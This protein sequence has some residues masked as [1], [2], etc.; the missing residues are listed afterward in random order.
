[1]QNLFTNGIV[2]HDLFRGVDDEKMVLK[3]EHEGE[4]ASRR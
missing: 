2:E 3:P 1:V 4:R